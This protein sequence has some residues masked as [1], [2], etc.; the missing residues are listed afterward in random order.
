MSEIIISIK[1]GIINDKT[2]KEIFYDCMETGKSPNTI[3]KEKG[4]EQVSDESELEKIVDK[5]LADNP[6]E[7]EK[8]KAGNKKLISFFMGQVMKET[9]GKANPKLVN[10]MIAKKL[11]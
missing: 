4:L 1:N 8:L 6:E 9:K 3:I 10:P 5:V 11:S 2:A 7:V